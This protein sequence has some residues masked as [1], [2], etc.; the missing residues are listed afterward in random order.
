MDIV[1]QRTELLVDDDPA[2]GIQWRPLQFLFFITA[3]GASPAKRCD[4]L[5]RQ[6]AAPDGGQVAESGR[7]QA[8][9]SC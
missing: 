7:R 3:R 8:A 9:R 5:I 6:R 2:P 1:D 4:L